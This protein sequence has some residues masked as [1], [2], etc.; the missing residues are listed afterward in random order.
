MF[1][2]RGGPMCPPHV[3]IFVY[4]QKGLY[5]LLIVNYKLLIDVVAKNRLERFLIA[6]VFD[7]SPKGAK[8]G[9]VA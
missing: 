1:V 5:V 9:C 4:M 7:A 6:S 3:Y 2:C 8:H